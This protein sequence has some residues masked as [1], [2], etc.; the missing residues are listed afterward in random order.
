MAQLVGTPMLTTAHCLTT[1]DNRIIW[2]R[3]RGAYNTIS[4]SET[5]QYA[6]LAPHARFVGHVYNAI[7]VD[8]FPFQPAEG[9]DLLFLSR[10]APEKGPQHA[11]AVAKR[12]GRRLTLA[13]KVDGYD[14]EFFEEVIRPLIDGDQIVY[15]G[16]ADA[17]QKRELYCSAKCLL[18]PLTWDE[19]FG[20]VMPEAMACGTPVIAFRR[21]SAPELIVH[22]KTGFVVDTVE[23]MADAVEACGKIDPAACRTHVESAFSPRAMAEAYVR[24]YED[25]ADMPYWA[26]RTAR[27]GAANATE[28]DGMPGSLAVA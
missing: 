6:G 8:S 1:S 21:G 2:S 22:G 14:G 18:M 7:D 23:E 20:L 13:G 25:L 10:L 15:L 3:Y 12:L 19:P 24:I 9:Q 16:E 28:K 17:A 11:I 4:R 5:R 27:S 26:R